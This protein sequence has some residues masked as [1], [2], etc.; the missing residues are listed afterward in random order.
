V[1]VLRASLIIVLLIVISGMPIVG[2]QS[3]EDR[4]QVVATTTLIADVARSVGGERVEVAAVIPPGADS[5]TYTPTPRDVAQIADADLVLINGM[6][7]EE[8]LVEIAEENARRAPVVVSLGIRVIASGGHHDDDDDEHHHDDDDYHHDDDDDGHHSRVEYIG[9]LGVDADCEGSDHGHNDEDDQLQDEDHDHG[10]CD[11]HVWMDPANVMIWAENIAAA[12]TEIDP[13]HAEIYAANAENYIAELAALQEEL[14]ALV[15]ELPHERRVLVTN[16]DFMAY[17]AAAYD[18]EIVTTIIPGVTTVA[19]VD[20]RTLAEL[21]DTLRHENVTAIFAEISLPTD[22]AETVAA[23]VGHEVAV[24]SLFSESL[25]P[26]GGP[27]STYID[28]MR[29]NV[30]AIVEALRDPD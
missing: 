18:F 24:I 9:V 1:K 12:L 10:S 25:S 13:D 28:Y 19:E 26:A 16:H 8:T 3:E 7:L 4:L 21:I 11:P 6:Y 22:L 30:T 29:Y 5:H 23:E 15:A 2:A 14:E 17:F 27:A 20:P